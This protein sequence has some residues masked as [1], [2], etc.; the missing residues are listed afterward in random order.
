MQIAGFNRAMYESSEFIL[1]ALQ[2]LYD[3]AFL[4]SC[5]LFPCDHLI[6]QTVLGGRKVL[7]IRF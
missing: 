4:V 1:Y 7:L 2:T 3:D 5:H 6:L